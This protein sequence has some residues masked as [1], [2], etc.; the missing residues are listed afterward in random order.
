[1]VKVLVAPGKYI[2]GANTLDEAGKFIAPLGKRALIVWDSFVCEM[3]SDQLVAGL[4]KNGVEAF[5]FVF[6]GECSRNQ[7]DLGIQKAKEVQ[8]DVIVGAGGGKAIDLAKAIAFNINARMVSLPT[9]ASNDAPTSSCSVYYTDEHVIDGFDV[10][11]RNPDAVLVD[12][13]VIATAPVRWLVSGIGDALATWFEAEA[14][15]KG[16][17]VAF[18]GGI[19]TMTAMTAA[20]LCF[21]TLMEYGLEAKSD[22]E[23]KVVTPALEKVVE[24][25]TLLSGIGWESG[26]LACAH[27]LGNSLTILECTHP[28]SH[29]EK[30]AFGLITQLC[31]DD[32]ITPE[33]REAVVDFMVEI[34]LPVT[35][36]DIGMEKLT[37]E[38][39]MAAAKTLTE[40]GNFIHNHVFP[41]T[42]FDLYSA[43]IAAD[44]YGRSR[45]AYYA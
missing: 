6:S 35:F 24:A 9:I 34:G 37:S 29:G 10:W 20:R 32:D 42:A 15:F 16:R 17:R 22:N 13:Y 7:R 4:S 45:K 39:L 2:Q 18:S 21:E 19:P 41:V 27:S 28:Y 36:A 40:P 1:M 5:S 14:A 3:I 23:M 44:A 12:T 25:S 30:V 38:E 33:Q 31:L 11:P 26:G 8:A 43:M